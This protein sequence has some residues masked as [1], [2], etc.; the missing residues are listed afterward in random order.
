MS[1]EKPPDLRY[2]LRL[3]KGVL[4][5]KP[6][7]DA[8]LS[9]A[10]STLAAVLATQSRSIAFPELSIPAV[11]ALRALM[12]KT[13]IQRLRATTKRLLDKVLQIDRLRSLVS[14]CSSHCC[15][16]FFNMPPCS[17]HCCCCT[18]FDLF[19]TAAL[20]TVVRSLT[21]L[22]YYSSHCRFILFEYTL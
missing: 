5:T 20:T 9:R 15:C 22:L 7:Q 21:S 13:N 19:R 8:I 12:K 11:V 16:T 6:G 1:S 4:A 18:F 14:P 2:Q 10:V 3:A 17:S